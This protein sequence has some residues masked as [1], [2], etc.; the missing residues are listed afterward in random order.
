[1]TKPLT[2]TLLQRELARPLGE[3]PDRFRL[4][5]TFEFAVNNAFARLG[6]EQVKAILKMRI[7]NQFAI[8]GGT[9]ER[10]RYP[11]ERQYGQEVAAGAKAE[12][13]GHGSVGTWATLS[14][15]HKIT[16]IVSWMPGTSRRKKS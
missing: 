12:L 8:L 2:I 6:F 9:G 5:Q 11:R 14:S 7:A 13:H 4:T 3:V 16:A 10:T 1:M 15:R